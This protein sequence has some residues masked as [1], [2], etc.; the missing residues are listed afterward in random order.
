M[1]DNMAIR[2][3][4]AKN[5][6]KNLPPVPWTP[7]DFYDRQDD[8][9]DPNDTRVFSIRQPVFTLLAKNHPEARDLINQL[10]GKRE[11][12]ETLFYTRI[13]CMINP[14]PQ[15][16]KVANEQIQAFN[17]LAGQI[18]PSITEPHAK[19]TFERIVAEV[20]E[21]AAMYNKDIGHEISF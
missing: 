11:L 20:A 7:P 18:Q 2:M 10:W 3:P 6:Y 1:E 8:R 4:E 15:D 9:R 14:C 21:V 12:I 13:V 16:R 5:P 17:K 19:S